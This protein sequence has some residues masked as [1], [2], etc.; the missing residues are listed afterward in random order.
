VQV[1]SEVTTTRRAGRITY[2]TLRGDER[3]IMIA[4]IL[5][6]QRFRLVTGISL[7]SAHCHFTLISILNN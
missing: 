1:T 2:P 6:F 3:R 5:L 4:K 7:W